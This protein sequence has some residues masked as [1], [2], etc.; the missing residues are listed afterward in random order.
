[1]IQ[2]PV[3]RIDLYLYTR[4]GPGLVLVTQDDFAAKLAALVSVGQV[5]RQRGRSNRV[6]HAK[7]LFEGVRYAR[8]A[9]ILLFPFFL[10][11]RSVSSSIQASLYLA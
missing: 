7:F 4:R 8:L 5:W 1:M 10:F 9:V 11:C 3:V 2:D 6:G